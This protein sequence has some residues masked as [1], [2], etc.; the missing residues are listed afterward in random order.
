MSDVLGFTGP[1]GSRAAGFGR[2]LMRASDARFAGSSYL[3]GVN[4]QRQYQQR[5]QYQTNT[6]QPYCSHD[7]SDLR[8]H[9]QLRE[10]Q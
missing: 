6:S 7:H 8:A 5:H 2:E 1:G 3:I 4:C 10:R 9:S